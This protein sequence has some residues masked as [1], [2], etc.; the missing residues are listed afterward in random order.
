MSKQ[1][2]FNAYDY[3]N[4]YGTRLTAIAAEDAMPAK[5]WSV[6]FTGSLKEC[7][8]FLYDG[9]KQPKGE[10]KLLQNHSK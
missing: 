7:E 8:A 10:I 3:I 6:L 1:K 9:K 4:H 5:Y 2:L